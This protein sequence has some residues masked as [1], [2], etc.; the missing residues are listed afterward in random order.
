MLGNG[1]L[2][3]RHVVAQVA[4]GVVDA[5]ADQVQV[6]QLAVAQAQ[7]V[8]FAVVGLQQHAIAVLPGHIDALLT[9]R[10]LGLGRLATLLT[11]LCGQLLSRRLGRHQVQPLEGAAVQNL[12]TGL[13]L[14]RRQA[15]ADMHHA[16]R[17]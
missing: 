14:P 12:V 1:R 16:A 17:V 8:P 4:D 9:R 2:Q 5:A 10:T 6:L 13:R 11:R 3:L 7:N 15:G